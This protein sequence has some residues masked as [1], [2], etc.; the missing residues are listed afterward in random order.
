M[1][2]ITSTARLIRVTSGE[3]HN[4]AKSNPVTLALSKDRG[5]TDTSL[6]NQGNT[7]HSESV[8]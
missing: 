7:S 5:S 1:V 3:I 6:G 2:H 8:I 4:K